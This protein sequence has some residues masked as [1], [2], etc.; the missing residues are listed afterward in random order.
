MRVPPPGRITPDNLTL[1]RGQLKLV[2]MATNVPAKEQDNQEAIVFFFKISRCQRFEFWVWKLGFCVWFSVLIKF[3]CSFDDFFD[4]FLCG[5]AVSNGPQRPHQICVLVN[6]FQRNPKFVASTAGH[7][8]A[9][10]TA[11]SKFL[12]ISF[13]RRWLVSSRILYFFPG[14]LPFSSIFPCFY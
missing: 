6:G 11:C 8:K 9:F 14:C 2:N 1:D 13:S 10:F 3:Y 7:F 4:E 5:F 12:A